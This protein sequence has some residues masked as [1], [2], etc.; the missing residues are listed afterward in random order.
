MNKSMSKF[1]TVFR[2]EFLS[3]V[4]NKPFIITTIII[5]LGISL[6]VSFPLV[7]DSVMGIINNFETEENKEI[8][9]Y[10]GEKDNITI[11][12]IKEILTEFE[13]TETKNKNEIKDA[14][15]SEDYIAGYIIDGEEFDL[16][17]KSP[18]MSTDFK[19]NE[20]VAL[21]N[22]NNQKAYLEDEGFSRKNIEE[23]F[24]RKINVNYVNLGKDINM[25]YFVGYIMI[26]FLYMSLLMY[27]QTVLVSVTTEKSTKTME[28]LI[29]SV[30]P[31]ELI[32]GKVFGVGCAALMQLALF[33]TTAMVVFTSTRAHWLEYSETAT[34][35]LDMS[36][37]QDVLLMAFVFFTLGFFAFAFIY[38]AFGSTISR[39]EDANAV[40][41][42]PT[43]LI[44][45]AFFLA[46]NASTAPNKIIARVSSFLPF[47]SPFV[48][49][50]RICVTEIS[51]TE[52][53]IAILINVVSVFFCGLFG[54]KLYRAGVLMYGKPPKMSDLIKAVFAR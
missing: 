52:T 28:L 48:M 10:I 21:I 6:G 18:D 50:M 42:L 45:I 32:F 36:L 1:F 2:F 7:K 13:I 11:K 12:E 38:A 22:L 44:L 39:V 27:G 17:N 54:A 4:K 20:I 14:V 5:M 3:T 53:L 25:T 41:I 51:Q 9:V 24:S 15:E 31:S 37:S 35:V 8:L 34:G 30:K 23:F 49:F 46:M 33:I 16:I 19:A 47:F 40:S 26:V 29:T 43:S